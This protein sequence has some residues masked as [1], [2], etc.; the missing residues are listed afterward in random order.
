MRKSVFA[1]TVAGT[2]AALGMLVAFQAPASA[3][4][5]SATVTPSS[6]LA[7]NAVV[8]VGA[9]GLTA[10]AAYTVGE[11]AEV[12]PGVLACNASGRVDV[13]AAGDGTLSTPLTVKKSFEGILFDG[14]S[15]GTVDCAAVTCVIGLADAA[16]NGPAGVALSFQ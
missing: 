16:G 12:S 9:S 7:D 5:P 1:K 11:C 6:G 15:Y 10:G 4:A 14:T 13:T 3:E 8:Q 2:A